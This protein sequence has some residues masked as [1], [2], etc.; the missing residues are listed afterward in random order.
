MN[1]VEYLIKSKQLLGPKLLT[2]KFEDKD[3]KLRIEKITKNSNNVNFIKKLERSQNKYRF[4]FQCILYNTNNT[5]TTYYIHGIYIYNQALY[6]V[7]ESQ[8]YKDLLLFFK[9]NTPIIK[10][11]SKRIKKMNFYITTKTKNIRDDPIT[12]RLKNSLYNTYE[13]VYTDNFYD[14][15]Y[16]YLWLPGRKEIY[17]QSLHDPQKNR[18]YTIILEYFKNKPDFI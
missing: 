10:E 18:H 17:L 6:V 11:I 13:I 8:N 5:I 14:V 3:L 16:V 7:E 2:R 15:E 4:K 1:Y 12:I 9:N